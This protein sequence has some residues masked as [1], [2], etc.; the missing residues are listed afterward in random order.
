MLDLIMQ[1]RCET[2]SRRLQ[3]AT[4]GQTLRGCQVGLAGSTMVP[5]DS[6]WALLSAHF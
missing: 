2:N 4:P 6:L 1:I 3:E 5:P